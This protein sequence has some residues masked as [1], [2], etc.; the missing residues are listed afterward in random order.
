MQMQE[1]KANSKQI[2]DVVAEFERHGTSSSVNRVEIK[3]R[4][5]RILMV[6]VY[7][8]YSMK[9]VEPAPPKMKKVYE[10]RANVLGVDVKLQKEYRSE[11][12][13][14][15]EKLTSQGYAAEIAEIEVED[16]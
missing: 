10:L 15:M 6:V 3:D 16:V 2:G 8:S 4:G 13:D 14:E 12:V 5:G 7:E 9:V 11:L 1:I